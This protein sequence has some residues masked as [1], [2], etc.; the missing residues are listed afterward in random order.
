MGETM[1]TAKLCFAMVA[2]L[3]FCGTAIAADTLEDVE[4][5]ILAQAEKNKTFSAKTATST[6]I[7]APGMSMKSKA[8]GT[9]EVA[10]RG[11]KTLL[12]MDSKSSGTTKIGDQPETKSE[13]K[14]LV[15]ADGQ[16][17]YT[18]TETAGQKMAMKMKLDPSKS[19]VTSKEGFDQMRKDYNLKLLPDEKIEG[20]GVYVIEAT[21]KKAKPD[22]TEVN[23]YY[24]SKDTGILVKSVMESKG[25]QSKSSITSS[26]SDIKPNADIKPER[27]VFKAP[28][29]VMVMDMT[30]TETAPS[31]EPAPAEK[32]AAKD[33]EEKKAEP[34]AAP[35][36]GEK[37]AS[38]KPALPKFRNPLK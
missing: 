38:K 7:T 15:I 9:Y 19:T 5:K 36:D 1:K 23:K 25:E 6:D 33:Q 2:G 14:S 29:G 18:L 24:Y 16:F 11:D 20:Q 28:E 30:Q 35:Q 12:R 27:F 31:A 13:S 22:T 8:E 21:P 17:Y 10:R 26:L 32:P 34:Q 3:A 37:K 4:K